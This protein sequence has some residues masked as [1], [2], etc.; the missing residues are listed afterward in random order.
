MNH[1]NSLEFI[2]NPQSIALVGITTTNPAHWTRL[3]LDS[4]LQFEFEHPIYLVNPKGGE[5][6]GLKV[7]TGL[8]D[9]PG[10]IDYVISTVPA[11][12]SIG[13]IEE[14]AGKGVKAI[15]FCTAG[16]R[17]TG[18]IRGAELEY[19]LTE[20][21]QEAGIRIIGPNCMGIYC[22]KSR[23]SF[24]PYFPKESGPV[25]FISQSGGSVPSLVQDASFRG[26]RFSKVISYGNACDLNES[27]FLDYLATDPDT[28][29]IVMYV[30]GV[31]D[32][33]R[34]RKALEEAAKKKV[35]ILFKG[36]T[37]QGG[38]RAVSTHTGSLAGNESAWEALC[39][40]AGVIRAYSLE[41]I[42]DILI[43]LLFMGI[44]KGRNAALIGVGGGFGVMITDQFEKHGLAV[45]A[46]STRVQNQLREFTQIAGNMLRNPIDYSQTIVEVEKFIKTI[47][48]LSQWKTIDFL[49]LYFQPNLVGES[50]EKVFLHQMPE[51]LS[52]AIREG[53][54]PIAIVFI[55]S[56]TSQEMR[57]VLPMIQKFV[58]LQLP[59][60]YSLSSVA[61]AID[62]VLNY[63]R[64]RS[65]KLPEWQ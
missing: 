36:G 40:Q 18:D 4:L 12:A 2:F 56:I 27:D 14:C 34:F 9:I 51:L 26:V 53:L 46:V 33:K 54:K 20:K 50:M 61:H 5:I 3:F 16:F 1:N 19:E 15:Q 37:T 64:T 44:P 17:E 58:S 6:H 21:A 24:G 43:T 35:V 38:A 32:G 8:R 42:V 55:L 31:R 30:E 25:G 62:V 48:I 60:Y 49:T 13:L 59:V 65:G 57:Q 22:P 11:E 63:G 45:P 7:Y 47:D 23:L 28:K 52:K 29:I 10:A 39:K 41:E